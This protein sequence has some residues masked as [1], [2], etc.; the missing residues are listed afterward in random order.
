MNFVTNYFHEL[1][2][3][4]QQ[5]IHHIIITDTHNAIIRDILANIR[6]D[7]SVSN[8]YVSFVKW[9]HM[10]KLTRYSHFK[11]TATLII[12]TGSSTA[13]QYN[14]MLAVHNG[15]HDPSLFHSTP[16]SK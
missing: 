14:N 5:L 1:P 4:V 16:P 9:V 3:D 15:R 2:I 6:H 8:P 12:T 13:D 10:D 11:A 7:V